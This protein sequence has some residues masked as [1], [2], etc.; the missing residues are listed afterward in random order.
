MGFIFDRGEQ[1][2]PKCPG[3]Q[4]SKGQFKPCCGTSHMESDSEIPPEDTRCVVT[5][6]HGTFAKHAPWMRD[7]SPLCMA[8]KGLPGT[9]IRRFC[10]SGGNTHTARLDAGGDLALYLRDLKQQFPED[11][12]HFVIAHSH[13]GNVALYAMESESDGTKLGKQVTGIVTLATPFLTL[14]KRSLPKFVFPSVWITMATVAVVS[15][16]AVW[17]NPNLELS[18]RNVIFV[19]VLFLVWLTA[20]VMSALIFRGEKVKLQ[21]FFQLLGE[22]TRKEQ[23]QLDEILKSLKPEGISGD[24]LLVMRP[25]GDE[26]NMALVVSQFFSWAQNRVLGFLQRFQDG[27]LGRSNAQES[28]AGEDS[29]WWT[30]LKSCASGCL[31]TCLKLVALVVVFLVVSSVEIAVET[32][33]QTD[34]ETA[35][36]TAEQTDVETAGQ[37]AVET[38]ERTD[39][40]TDVLTV[41]IHAV[42]KVFSML[43]PLLD[44]DDIPWPLLLL[45]VMT[46]VMFA[47]LLIFFVAFGVVSLIALLG[48]LLAALPFGKDAMFLNHFVST[49]AE[50]APVGASP[51]HI[52][53]AEP[54][55]GEVKPGLAH[56]GIYED[57]AAIAQIVGWI[58]NRSDA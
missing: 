42:S 43:D 22:R 40:K 10:W 18:W 45:L 17:P 32:A 4:V 15:A 1:D 21:K 23:P 6:V 53:H 52:F 47:G 28:A 12:R 25:L 44:P 7:H 51:A 58:T 19:T 41:E 9:S 55:G 50:P 34:V 49:T 29:G 37:T 31:V 16:I 24:K 54:E 39:E 27:F 36:Q 5:L 30:K 26:A 56:S 8:L 14:R 35:E 48:L 11:T 33:E 20:T 38:D 3:V 57:K 46:L 2:E 13:G